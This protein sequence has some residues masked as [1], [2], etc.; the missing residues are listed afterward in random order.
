MK[1]RLIAFTALFIAAALPVSAQTTSTNPLKKPAPAAAAPAAPAAP[2]TAAPATEAKKPS[3]AQMAS[4]NRMKECGAE[5]QTMK[6]AGKTEG[7]TWRQFSSEC[8]KK[9]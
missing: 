2:A 8:L 5:W 1:T 9:K 6:K 4:R 7:K 3:E